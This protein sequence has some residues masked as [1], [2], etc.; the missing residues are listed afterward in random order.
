MSFIL[1]VLDVSEHSNCGFLSGLKQ[2][3]E[4]C[5]PYT[6]PHDVDTRSLYCGLR[7]SKGS[8]GCFVP[9]YLAIM[10]YING[11]MYMGITDV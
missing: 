4:G 9:K 3:F 1:N 6:H 7:H 2:S 5:P 10:K 11:S 8:Y